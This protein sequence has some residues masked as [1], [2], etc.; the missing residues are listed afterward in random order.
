MS[1][2]HKRKGNGAQ[3]AS[4]LS[5]FLPRSSGAHRVPSDGPRRSGRPDLTTPGGSC[6]AATC[7]LY[8]LS[9]ICSVPS[10]LRS[11]GPFSWV[12]G[13]PRAGTRAPE[14]VLAMEKAGPSKIRAPVPGVGG[15]PMAFHRKNGARYVHVCFRSQW[16]AA[17]QPTCLMGVPPAYTCANTLFPLLVL[18]LLCDAGWQCHQ[19]VD[20]SF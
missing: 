9:P 17:A 7:F 5:R 19:R 13:F 2:A 1:P 14:R 10:S 8:L 12:L 3:R 4:G 11:H 20:A 18:L 16:P 15:F 6:H